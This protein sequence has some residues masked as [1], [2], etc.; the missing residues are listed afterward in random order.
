MMGFL[1]AQIEPMVEGEPPTGNWRASELGFAIPML[2]WHHV[3]KWPCLHG[4]R[5]GRS[6]SSFQRC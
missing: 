5:Y 6:A 3:G 2:P 4:T 1:R